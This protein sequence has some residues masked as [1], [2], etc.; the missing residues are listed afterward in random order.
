MSTSSNPER[1]N[2]DAQY[3]R[4]KHVASLILV[5]AAPILIALPPRKLDLYTFT[6]TTAFLLSANQLTLERSGRSILGHMNPY[7][8]HELPSQ[9]AHEVQDRLRKE[10]LLQIEKSGRSLQEA[11]REIDKRRP[12]GEKLWMG[13]EKEGWK[14]RRLREEQEAIEEGR[15]YGSLIMEQIWDVWNWGK[16]GEVEQERNGMD[17]Q[18]RSKEGGKGP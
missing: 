9:R 7:S 12:L 16:K 6:L 15:G 14:E 18:D 3:L 4:F 11:E 13:G 1:P 10:R 5:V 2:L 8:L 17:G